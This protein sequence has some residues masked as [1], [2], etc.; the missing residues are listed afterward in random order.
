MGLF[1]ALKRGPDDDPEAERRREQDVERVEQGSIPLAAA[2]RL[3]ELA[4]GA[5][6][7]TSGLSVADFALCRA[8]GVRPVA[9]VMG[10]SVY[11][12]GWQSYPW[13]SS[14]QADATTV[15]LEALTDAWNDARARALR[16][17]AEEAE[18]AGCHAVV[19]VT[20][21]RRDHAFLSDEIEIVV[22][23]T[24]VVLDGASGD[25]K[26]V[27]TDLSLPDYVL[28]RR[29]GYEPVGIVT[30]TSVLYVVPGQ[31]T[32]GLTTGWQRFQPNRE[33]TDFTQGVYEARELALGRANDEAWRR[34][35][36]G[37]V[38]LS[39]EQHVARREV[40]QTG[41]KRIDLIVTLH[42]V[43]TGI[44]QPGAYRPIDVYTA[45]R[46]GAAPS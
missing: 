39:I 5:M 28:L 33:L 36:T 18:L 12:V 1:D 24:A 43:G 38:G 31:T 23:G 35:A 8:A 19:D 4:G 6:G 9:Q 34:G 21:E 44:A 41:S 10:S 46:Q 30:A 16:R 25:A 13:G 40:E 3:R 20:F 26:P 45:I 11:K 32:R 27:L 14:W 42:V 15:E 37:L 17:L 2:Q 7:F 29:A 22:N